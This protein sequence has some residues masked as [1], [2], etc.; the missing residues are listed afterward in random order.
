MENNLHQQSEKIICLPHN[1]IYSIYKASND[2][3]QIR[4]I[5]L[6]NLIGEALTDFQKTKVKLFGISQKDLYTIKHKYFEEHS[7]GNNIR[8]WQELQ[9]KRLDAKKSYI[10]AELVLEGKN[11]DNIK[12][13][14]FVDEIEIS[15][16]KMIQ[17]IETISGV[18]I[19]FYDYLG[20]INY[21]IKA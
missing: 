11:V 14:D 9:I 21:F 1:V 12:V 19:H 5:E 3:Y 7:L 10:V 16:K 20:N 18:N 6:H 4:S 15:I 13:N 17:E 8:K 2:S